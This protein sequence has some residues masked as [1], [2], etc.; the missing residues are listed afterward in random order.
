MHKLFV[1]PVSTGDDESSLIRMLHII[2]WTLIAAISLA[3]LLALFVQSANLLR[4][5]GILF[6]LNVL[7][8]GR[9]PV[10]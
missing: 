3:A 4:W 7:G 1:P 6:G 2:G 8:V 9:R 10:G 5:I